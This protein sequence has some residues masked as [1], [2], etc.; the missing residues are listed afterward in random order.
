MGTRLYPNTKNP[1]VLEK[2][3]CVPV[4]THLR[5]SF[6]ENVVNTPR[7]IAAIAIARKKQWE[8]DG[9]DPRSVK[10]YY[11]DIDSDV[12]QYGQSQLDYF[13]GSYLELDYGRYD[14]FLMEGWGRVQTP[15][16][17]FTRHNYHYASGHTINLGEVI[18]LLHYQA[19]EGRLD[20]DR[21]NERVR[22]KVYVGKP[23]ISFGSLS[24]QDISPKDWKYGEWVGITELEGLYWS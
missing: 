14:S 4:G 7:I 3:A 21:S 22:S 2:L 12:R 15:G 9:R 6:C 18:D 23:F 17:W 19:E 5:K 8:E 24:D 16:P 11:W 13:V 10:E 1:D 20:F